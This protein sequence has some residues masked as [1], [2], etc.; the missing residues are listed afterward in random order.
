G[1]DEGA[2]R[3]GSRRQV[4][5][6]AVARIEIHGMKD[7]AL[8]DVGQDAGESAEI[9]RPKR[10]WTLRDDNRRWRH[11]APHLLIVVDR[12]TELLEVVG[13]LDS[14]RG[15]AGRLDRG[16][17]QGDQHGDDGDDDQE[18]DQ[19]EAL[20]AFDHGCLPLRVTV[21]SDLMWLGYS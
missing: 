3:L 4:T 20:A 18:L 19:G 11:P 17:E 2:D 16:Q 7:R 1:A 6:I 21:A 5:R 12:Q 14:P 15:L 13:A 8:L 10:S 9:A